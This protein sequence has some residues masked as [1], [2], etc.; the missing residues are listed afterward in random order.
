MKKKKALDPDE[1]IFCD[2]TPEND[3]RIEYEDDEFICFHDIDPHGP[4]HLLVIP[5]EHIANVDSLDASHLDMV[6]RMAELGKNLLR[7]HGIEVEKEDID[8]RRLGFHLPPYRSVDHLHLHCIGLPLKPFTARAMFPTFKT[9]WY[10][11]VEHVIDR[12][13][14]LKFPRNQL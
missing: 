1:C 11:P 13:E 8:M 14:K 5:R 2:V 4:I 3:F 6:K 10:A 7:K 12:L 9:A